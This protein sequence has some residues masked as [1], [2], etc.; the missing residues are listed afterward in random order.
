M[1][2]D[3]PGRG[4]SRVGSAIALAD[5]RARVAW[6]LGPVDA[7]RAA[8]R[9]GR[10]TRRQL[11]LVADVTG[12]TAPPIPGSGP[13]EPTDAR[14]YDGFA[15]LVPETPAASLLE[16]LWYVRFAEEGARTLLVARDEA[17]L[18]TFSTWMLDAEGQREHASRF[19]EAFH[20]LEDGE[21]LLEGVFT[22]PHAR[23]RGVGAAGIAAACAWAA[24]NGAARVWVYPYLDNPAVLPLNVRAGFEPV[25]VR[26]EV[27]SLGQARAYEQP[28]TEADAAAWKAAGG[29]RPAAVS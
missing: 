15:R 2:R 8:V 17:G 18:P 26:V 19:G 10:R 12:R 21:M 23:G 3:G 14:S 16:L 27:T 6:R 28:L 9:V 25:A 24:G 4:R 22:Y 20:C 5:Q 1:E 29:R 13:L 7:V 11:A